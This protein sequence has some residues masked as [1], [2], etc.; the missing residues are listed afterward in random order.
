MGKKLKVLKKEDG[1]KL[2]QEGSVAWKLLTPETVGCKNM[3]LGILW[4]DKNKKT[5]PNVHPN[6]EE[7]FYILKGHGKIIVENESADIE[8]GMAIYIIPN[9][10]HSFENTGNE[11]MVFLLM[12]APQES[13]EELDKSPWKQSNP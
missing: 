10:I 9:V 2:E 11:K 8:P 5:K 4:L 13:M 12:H 7:M 3:D 1:I 6:S